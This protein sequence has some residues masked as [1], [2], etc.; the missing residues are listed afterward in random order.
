MANFKGKRMVE[1]DLI[2]KLEDI[3]PSGSS[4]T[5]GDG[6]LINDGVLSVNYGTGL[7]VTEEGVLYATGGGGTTYTAGEGITIDANDE[8]SANI[9]AGSGIVVD[10]DLTDDSVV[11]MIDQEDI[12]YKSDLA[13]VATTGDYDD[14]T[15][16]PTIPTATSDLNNDSGF[17]TSTDTEARPFYDGVRVTDGTMVFSKDGTNY[18][19][20]VVLGS[21]DNFRVNLNA[22]DGDYTHLTNTPT[23]P[24]AVSGTND[25]TNWTGLTIGSD[26]YA[27][28][29]GG[30]GSSYTF[31]DGLTESNGIVT[32]DLYTNADVTIAGIGQNFKL[33][34]NKVIIGQNVDAASATGESVTIGA[35]NTGFGQS[36]SI[37][38]SAFTGSYKQVAIGYRSRA[39]NNK[40]GQV[41]IG[42]KNTI[43]NDSSFVFADG[44][45]NPT[46]PNL[47]VIKSD[48]TVISKNLPAV[49]GTDGTY[50]LTA[51]TSSGTT[52]YSWA[53]GGSG[54]KYLH[55]VKIYANF[56]GTTLLFEDTFASTQSTAYSNVTTFLTDRGYTVSSN[57][58]QPTK[59]L[60]TYATSTLTA[61]AYR[62]DNTSI[63]TSTISIS[64]SGAQTCAAWQV[65]S[66]TPSIQDEVIAL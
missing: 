49:S 1:E 64:S 2:K 37:G 56:G 61:L 22:L 62:T 39:S 30:S 53:T 19:S 44:D 28:P 51:T 54:G 42:N 41:V 34:Y 59:R 23:I 32:N 24:A 66:D 20:R 12:P 27:I 7:D 5:A 8:I 57:S 58:D 13:T 15:N 36:V 46:N 3:D 11:V 65:Q 21:G 50:Q 60:E 48:G 14:L 4:Y 17:I 25:G 26:T 29:A 9:K 47:M 16:K 38:S 31:T 40:S 45:N 55:K 52:T 63:V 35:G 33:E 10:T 6:I 18:S 43:D